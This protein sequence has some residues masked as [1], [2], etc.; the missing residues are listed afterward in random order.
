MPQIDKAPYKTK[1]AVLFVI[2][3]RP[4]TTTRVFEQIRIAKPR[5]LYIAADA[6]RAN[7]P[8]DEL[9]CNQAREVI[10]NVDWDCK[11]ETL[12]REANLGCKEGVS[13]AVTWFFDHEKEGI[14]LE[15]DCLPANSFFKFCD[16]LLNR[17]RDDT[18]IRHITGCNLQQGKKWGNSSY[19]FS[20]RTHVWGWASW[21]RV[22]KDYDKD[23]KQYNS[24]DI[25]EKIQNIYQDPIVVDCWVNIFK[26]L[27]ENKINSWAYQLDFTNFFNN[28]LTIIPNS[29]LISNI[30]FGESATHTIDKESIY[31]NIPVTEIDEITNP[32]F[33]LP[34]KEADLIVLNRDFDVAEKRRKQNLLRKKIKRWFKSSLQKAASIMFL[35]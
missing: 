28:G 26:G 8:D 21:K 12:L 10:K 19:Y 25:K 33:M 9:L 22:W 24:D 11:V 2:F 5:R 30:G 1:S 14:I 23:L 17:Y 29:N 7:F 3:N 4:E 31:A 13:S 6:P 27:K 16:T 15:D 35:S 34:E 20:N 32:V 18:R